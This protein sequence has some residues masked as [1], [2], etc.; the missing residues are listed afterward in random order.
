MS[1]C[2]G[3]LGDKRCFYELTRYWPFISKMG[4]FLFKKNILKLQ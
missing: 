3:K 1:V 2:M 4:G